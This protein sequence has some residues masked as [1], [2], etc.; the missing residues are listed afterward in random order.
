MATPHVVGLVLYLQAYEG[1]TSAN[2]PARLRAL[3]TAGRV[4]SPGTGSP[5][6]II[7]NGSS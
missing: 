7:F 4:T 3:A 6:Y 1:V 5:N 2:I